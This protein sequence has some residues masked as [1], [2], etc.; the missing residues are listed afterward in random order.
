MF[1]L[2]RSLK[3][4]GST[5]A[6]SLRAAAV[7]RRSIESEQASAA[8]KPTQV[9]PAVVVKPSAPAKVTP[10]APAAAKDKESAPP[11]QKSEKSEPPPRKSSVIISKSGGSTKAAANAS[12]AKSATVDTKTVPAVVSKGE[13]KPAPTQPPAVAP[14]TTNKP[15]VAAATPTDPVGSDSGRP[16]SSRG[17]GSAGGAAVTTEAPATQGAAD[18]RPK[19]GA[20]VPKAPANA[21]VA[22]GARPVSKGVTRPVSQGK[23]TSPKAVSKA[24]PSVVQQKTIEETRVLVQNYVTNALDLA[25]AGALKNLH[26]QEQSRTQT[27]AGEGG[28]LVGDELSTVLKEGSRI[29]NKSQNASEVEAS[30]DYS[31][32][33]ER[34]L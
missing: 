14:A 29:T 34:S 7:R 30:L 11:S 2:Q 4:G 15:I 8:V 33:F 27:A 17:L 32:D 31:M 5:R 10:V 1:L 18:S 25:V 24:V 12:D 19:A 16:K 28:D 13:A 21:S 6:A 9:A 20:L 26:L 3:S 23:A 22:S